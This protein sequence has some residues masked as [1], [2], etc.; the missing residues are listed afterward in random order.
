M[1]TALS[2]GIR[3]TGLS[4][5]PTE[6][7]AE[8]ISTCIESVR[9]RRPRARQLLKHPYFDTIRAE[10]CAVK[11]SAEALVHSS[12]SD[13]HQIM[14]ECAASLA[15]SVSRTSSE[16]ADVHQALCSI[17]SGLATPPEAADTAAAA[18]QAAGLEPARSAPLFA[19]DDSAV[20][21]AA[22]LRMGVPPMPSPPRSEPGRVVA[23]PPVSEEADAQESA[24]A[25]GSARNSFE[26][27]STSQ[28][29][30]A[31]DLDQSISSADMAA[32]PV[33]TGAR[34][35]SYGAWAVLTLRYAPRPLLNPFSIRR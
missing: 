31:H 3:P 10:K 9:Q 14:A 15:G 26:T 4:K 13:L 7:L 25:H 17:D 6:E 32:E 21:S 22:A 16:I 30:P 8:F 23:R 18:P 34:S 19:R 12:A 24:L 29:V 28:P 27:A 20:P 33:L 2:Q 35:M 11:L 5:V 1:H